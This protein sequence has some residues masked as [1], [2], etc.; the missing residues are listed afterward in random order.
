MKENIPLQLRTSLKQ[1]II[2]IIFGIFLFFVLLEAGLRLGGFILLSLQEHSNLQSIKQKGAY[3]I[4]CLGESTT[5]GQYPQFLEEDLNQRNIGVHF[6]AIDDGI[7]GV[8]TTAILNQIESYLA[9]YHPDMVVTMMG[10][11]DWGE[12]IPFETATTFKGILFIR[13]FKTYKLIK[14]LWLHILTKVKEIGL[15]KPNKEFPKVPSRTRLKEDHV[16]PIPSQDKFQ[17]A[18]EVKND[19]EYFKLGDFYWKQGK[20]HQAEELFKKAIELNPRN[21]DAYTGLG[22]FYRGQGQLPKAEELFK[23]AI[24]LNPKNDRAYT[25][26]GWASL[27]QGKSSQAE[28][29]FKKA[30]KIN[31]RKEDAYTG[32]GQLYLDQSKF[33]QAEEVFKKAIEVNPKN[34]R[35]YTGLGWASLEQ[36]TLPQIEVLFKKIVELNSGNDPAYGAIAVLYEEIDRPELAKE[37]AQKANSLRL[38]YCNP[39]TVNNYRKL[40][41]ILDQKGIKLVCA[42]YPMRNIEPL[43]K[44]FA[45]DTGV[46]FVDNQGIFREAVK[47]TSYKEYFTDMFGGDF[48]HCN[49]K[50]NKLLAQNIADVILREVFKLKNPGSVLK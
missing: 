32:L 5:Q 3:R 6:S 28:E 15:H 10:V 41:E 2:L 24:E 26:L 30:V 19:D 34:D 1:R 31:P 44:I 43:K 14:F 42:Q 7:P 23:K 48:G 38:E 47:K 46:I 8:N 18:A 29:F 50:G 12:H 16:E 4:L 13:S 40:K 39:V 36:N 11:N 35:A 21:D 9:K 37:Y 25:G 45:K 20:I 49:D 33:S 17:K 22:W 27:E